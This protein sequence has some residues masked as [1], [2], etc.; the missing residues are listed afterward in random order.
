MT[1]RDGIR[2]DLQAK[3]QQDAAKQMELKVLAISNVVTLTRTGQMSDRRCLEEVQ[4]I[5]SGDA[6][7]IVRVGEEYRPDMNTGETR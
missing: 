2:R 3:R 7:R 1:F 5:L 4:R 6:D